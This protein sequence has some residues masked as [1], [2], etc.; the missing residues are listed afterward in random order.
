M[1]LISTLAHQHIINSETV[2]A[3]QHIS[4]SAHQ[5][6]DDDFNIRDIC[7][8]MDDGEKRTMPRK[9][10]GAFLYED[11]TTLLFS[12][13][14]YGKSLLVFQFA[15]AAAT[16]TDF[17][18]CAALCNECEPMKVLVID[19]ELN[20]GIIWKRHGAVKSN[21]HPY[22][23]NL[24]YL[25]EK[26]E[27]KVVLGFELIEKIEQAALAHKAKLVIIDN[28]SKLLPDAVRPDIATLIISML[29][30]SASKLVLLSW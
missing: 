11:T 20:D 27:N 25:H 10:I 21:P 3:N 15:F 13:T 17:D 24:R 9:I 2:S 30:R 26:I 5:H 12:R 6:I 7:V 1:P 8:L 23:R 14:N 28:I 4:T 19:L 16:G 29:N 18:S 22:M